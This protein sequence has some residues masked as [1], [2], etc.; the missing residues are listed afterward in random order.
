MQMNKYIKYIGP[1]LLA[2]GIVILVFGAVCLGCAGSAIG[3]I[4]DAY[5]YLDINLYHGR[6]EAGDACKVLGMLADIGLSDAV[7]SGFE[8]FAI[9]ARYPFFILG[10]LIA[11]VGAVFTF[12]NGVEIP[13]N[14]S[15]IFSGIWKKVYLFC[16]AFIEWMRI[17]ISGCRCPVCG[18]K[19]IKGA[20]FCGSCGAAIEDKKD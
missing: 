15:V 16:D 8:S 17:K 4:E 14:A 6:F 12:R 7:I 19:L 18:E 20:V 3:R 9:G 1:A 13:E 10:I 11:V 2:L 5:Y